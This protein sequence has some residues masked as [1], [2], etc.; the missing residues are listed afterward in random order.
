MED[1]IEKIYE[2][3]K[4]DDKKMITEVNKDIDN[5]LVKLSENNI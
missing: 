4:T 3:V 2:A 1:L 5:I